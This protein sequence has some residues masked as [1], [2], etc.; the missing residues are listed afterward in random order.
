[1]VL[2]NYFNDNNANSSVENGTLND[3]GSPEVEESLVIIYVII[4]KMDLNL[5]CFSRYSTITTIILSALQ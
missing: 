2:G 1:M 5:K 4:G 3:S